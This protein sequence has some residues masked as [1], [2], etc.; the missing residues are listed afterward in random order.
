M[1]CQTE[2]AL[3]NYSTRQRTLWHFSQVGQP[4]CVKPFFCYALTLVVETW[5]LVAS[6]RWGTRRNAELHCL[7]SFSMHNGRLLQRLLQVCQRHG[8]FLADN[9]LDKADKLTK[10]GVCRKDA[11][12]LYDFTN[13]TVATIHG[14]VGVDDLT[15]G[16]GLLKRT[17]QPP[18]KFR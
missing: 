9:A 7:E 5:F 15:D 12:G 8:P 16:R 18:Q 11:I 14:I 6:R 2:V 10:R 1:P 17:V 4:N 13:L 3:I